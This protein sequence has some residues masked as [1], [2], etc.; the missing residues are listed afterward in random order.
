M[1]VLSNIC[2]ILCVFCVISVRY[3]VFRVVF[4]R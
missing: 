2:E 1:S 4:V 3:C